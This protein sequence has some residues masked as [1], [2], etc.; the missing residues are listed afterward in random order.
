[1]HLRSLHP[2][3]KSVSAKTF[4]T[5]N[6]G[7]LLSLQILEG[8]RLK[9][10]VTKTPALLICVDGTVVFKN[11]LGEQVTLS[12]GDYLEIPPMV[13]HWLEASADS[14]LVLYR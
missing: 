7:K 5:A 11:E 3:D 6:D 14:Q 1:M 4:F 2:Q 9:E 12:S 10:H 8:Q 13:L